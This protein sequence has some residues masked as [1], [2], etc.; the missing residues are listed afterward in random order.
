MFVF[1]KLLNFQ[2]HRILFRAL[3]HMAA[4][5]QIEI[6]NGFLLMHAH[7]YFQTEIY[8]LIQI[9]LFSCPEP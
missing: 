3:P 5:C 2:L 7:Y 6:L 8:Q 9:S 1:R 4:E